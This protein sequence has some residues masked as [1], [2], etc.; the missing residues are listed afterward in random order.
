MENDKVKVLEDQIISLHHIIICLLQCHPINIPI[1]N[2]LN[3]NPRSKIDYT[4]A[5]DSQRELYR[6]I[7]K[8]LEDKLHLN[9]SE[10]EKELMIEYQKND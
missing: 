8:K 4:F 10:Q 5:Y 9:V 3:T 6:N 2:K 7:K 1:W